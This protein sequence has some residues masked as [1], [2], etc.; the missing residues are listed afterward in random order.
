M[1]EHRRCGY[2]FYTIE[3]D[4]KIRVVQNSGIQ[5]EVIDNTGQKSTYFGFIED[6]WELAYGGLCRFPSSNVNGLDTQMMCWWRYSVSE[7]STSPMWDIKTSHGLLLS[8]VAQ[9]FYLTDLS[10]WEEAP[11]CIWEANNSRS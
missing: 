9:V 2:M 7:A 3:K 10:F 8:T 6:I 5:Y 11:S 4:R 1:R